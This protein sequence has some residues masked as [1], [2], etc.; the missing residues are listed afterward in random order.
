MSSGVGG[1][2]EL[3]RD[4]QVVEEIARDTSYEYTSPPA[5]VLQEPVKVLPGQLYVYD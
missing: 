4:G 3:V 1:V 2:L 5:H